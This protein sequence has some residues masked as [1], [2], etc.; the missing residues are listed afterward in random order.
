MRCLTLLLGAVLLLCGPAAAENEFRQLATV[1]ATSGTAEFWEGTF[2][3]TRVV[4]LKVKE[5]GKDGEVNVTF[6]KK[7]LLVLSEEVDRLLADGRAMKPGAVVVSS[8]IPLGE[9]SVDLAL[10]KP[11]KETLRVLVV[12]DGKSE[13]SFV[14]DR[15]N[16]APFKRAVEQGLKSL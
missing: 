12:K 1:T 16:R 3:G 14:L 13:R 2:G 7:Q 11:G 5:A 10:V 8:T 9:G 15:A 4:I 6:D